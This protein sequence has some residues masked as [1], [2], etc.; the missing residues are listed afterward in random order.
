MGLGNWDSYLFSYLRCHDSHLSKIKSPIRS[1][2][3]CRYWWSL[4]KLLG[5]FISEP[6]KQ[7]QWV[8][9]GSTSLHFE[10]LSLVEPENGLAP[11]AEPGSAL[12]LTW[13]MVPSP[14]FGISRYCQAINCPREG[15]RFFKCNWFLCVD[16]ISCYHAE[17]TYSRNLVGFLFLFFL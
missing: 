4:H 2:L 13:L 5:F 3:I 8:R 14:Q 15:K 9:K 12:A 16:L 10:S 11:M 6:V 17:L 7:G 1:V